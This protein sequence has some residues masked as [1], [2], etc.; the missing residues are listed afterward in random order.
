MTTENTPAAEEIVVNDGLVLRAVD[1]RYVTVLHR[2]V[3]K[4]SAGCRT[5]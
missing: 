3:E 1:E 4:T 5:P 2:L